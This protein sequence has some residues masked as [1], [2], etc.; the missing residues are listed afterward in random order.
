MGAEQ[1]VSPLNCFPHDTCG[2]VHLSSFGSDFSIHWSVKTR[3]VKSIDHKWTL[4]PKRR[5]QF[6]AHDLLKVYKD[7]LKNTPKKQKLLHIPSNGNGSA[8]SFINV[9]DTL[10][11]L[12]SLG[13]AFP[14][15]GLGRKHVNC[16]TP[17]AAMRST[18]SSLKGRW[19]AEG[20]GRIMICT[21][22]VCIPS[23][24]WPEKEKE[25]I[26]AERF[27]LELCSLARL[28]CSV[29]RLVNSLCTVVCR[30]WPAVS[31]GTRLD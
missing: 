17:L 12:F 24:L 4:I 16:K 2:N 10:P 19:K 29:G 22:C 23:T 25:K 18:T 3:E 7:D 8:A 27:C 20:C 15:M 9:S 28:S 1:A 30:F 11:F 21:V 5:T 14:V 6:W 31:R 13:P 26:Y